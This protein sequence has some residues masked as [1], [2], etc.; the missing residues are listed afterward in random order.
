MLW[1]ENGQRRGVPMDNTRPQ[2]NKNNGKSFTGNS[3]AKKPREN[4]RETGKLTYLCSALQHIISAYSKMSI[5]VTREYLLQRSI[6]KS[7]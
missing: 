4:V 7:K 6:F 2:N 1:H 5:V 3:I